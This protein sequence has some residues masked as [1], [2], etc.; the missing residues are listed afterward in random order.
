MTIVLFPVYREI[1]E[2]VS[3][4]DDSF[5]HPVA[6]SLVWSLGNPRNT[7]KSDMTPVRKSGEAAATA[8]RMVPF[9]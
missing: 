5:D 1:W 2:N 8:A 4:S 9:W 3:S 6:E 7:P